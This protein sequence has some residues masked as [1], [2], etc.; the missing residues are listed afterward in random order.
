MNTTTVTTNKQSYPDRYLRSC[1]IQYDCRSLFVYLVEMEYI[2]T[3]DSIEIILQYPEIRD[4]RY[5]KTDQHFNDFLNNV[6]KFAFPYKK[7]IK[8]AA[9]QQQTNQHQSNLVQFYPFVFTDENRIRQ[10][11]YCRSAKS[12]NHIICLISY[13]PWYTL[14]I[15][16]LNKIATIINEKETDSLY[17]FI[18]ALYEYELKEPGSFEEILSHDGM[19]SIKFWSPDRR[20]VPSIKENRNLIKFFN[21][22]DL[23]KIIKIFTALLL[24]RNIMI[25]SKDLENMTACALS[26]EYLIYP[27]EWLYAFAPIMPEHIDSLVYNQPFPFIYGVHTLIYDQL[28]VAQKENALV[29]L[30]DDKLIVNGDN[31]KLP[32]KVLDLLYS[33]YLNFL[34]LKMYF[35]SK[36]CK[37]EGDI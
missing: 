19:E 14:F 25:V 20:V 30:V 34:H 11:G 5:F 13:L 24:E 4:Y 31:D 29:L 15:S 10:Y 26:L 12:G 23:D 7:T 21:F 18:E 37:I 33:K 16:L 17:H 22:F 35:S 2:E 3:T 28:N 32:E 8:T 36:R 1:P 6:K 9:K 27:L